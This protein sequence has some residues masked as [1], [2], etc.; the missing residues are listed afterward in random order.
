MNS[1]D[2]GNCAHEHTFTEGSIDICEDC[3]LMINQQDMN[4]EKEWRYYGLSDTR[5]NSDPNRCYA[6]RVTDRVIDRDVEKMG[7]SQKIILLANQIYDQVTQG[8]IYRGN[9][10]KGIIFAC[11]FHAYKMMGHPQS[12]EHLIEVFQMNRKIG[13]K[14][15]K[16]VN[17]NAPKKANFRNFHIQMDD[18]IREIMDKFHATD[19]QKKEA[20]DLYHQVER[21]SSLFNRSRPQSVACGIVRYYISK[22]NK[23]I[24]MEEFQTRV[25]LSEVTIQRLV[26][27]IDRI[28]SHSSSSVLEQV[29]VK[30]LEV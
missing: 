29:Q 9:S 11:I 3:G 22:K 25:H 7:F 8:K 12:C 6:R 20:I 19:N 16:Y 30:Q 13:L 28:L 15:L 1:E 18:L 17:L 24:T 4:F 5:H 14:G 2:N 23:D 21:R 10:R 26:S 27:E